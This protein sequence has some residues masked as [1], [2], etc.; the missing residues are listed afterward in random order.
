MPIIGGMKQTTAIKKLVDSL[1]GPTKAAAAL[2]V[3]QPTVSGWLSGKHG[4]S[5]IVAMRAERVTG[6]PAAHLCP[7]MVDLPPAAA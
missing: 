6:I 5:A 1:G 3:K 4:V 7:G 2:G